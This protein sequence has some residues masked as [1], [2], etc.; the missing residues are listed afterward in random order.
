MQT[1]Y[2]R[3]LG[4]KTNHGRQRRFLKS[5]GVNLE[6][7][8]GG[9]LSWKFRTNSSEKNERKLKDQWTKGGEEK[10]ETNWPLELRGCFNSK[11]RRARNKGKAAANAASQLVK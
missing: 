6:R 7:E 3:S 10:S 1:I 5:T 11:V 2:G 4:S 9:V 8:D